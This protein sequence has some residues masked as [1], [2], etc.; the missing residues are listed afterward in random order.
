M[1]DDKKCK[2][3]LWTEIENSFMALAGV[4]SLV[5]LSEAAIRTRQPWRRISITVHGGVPAEILQDACW[6]YGIDT[7]TTSVQVVCHGGYPACALT[8]AVPG[9]MHW[10]ADHLLR[11]YAHATGSFDVDSQPVMRDGKS[12]ASRITGK[13][14]RPWG[15]PA[16]PKSMNGRMLRAVAATTG[17]TM[18]RSYSRIERHVGNSSS[19][20]GPSSGA[21]MQGDLRAA[22]GDMKRVLRGR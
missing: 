16:R 18:Q 5:S 12:S 7:V 3:S 8:I 11:Q 15:V 22:L 10:M 4:I 6:M 19:R 9:K 2:L 21:G 17:M 1:S 13:M 14:W 20:P